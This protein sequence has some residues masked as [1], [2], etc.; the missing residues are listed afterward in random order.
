MKA[1]IEQTTMGYHV[2][3]SA[4]RDSFAQLLEQFKAIIPRKCRQFDP[5]RRYWFVDLRA[6]RKLARFVDSIQ[7]LGGEVER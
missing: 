3:L 5:A 6:G 4:A 7:S 2:T 1:T